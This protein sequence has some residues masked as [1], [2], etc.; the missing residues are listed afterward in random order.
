METVNDV[1]SIS[2]SLSYWEG[3]FQRSIVKRPADQYLPGFNLVNPFESLN[4][5]DE[6]LPNLKVMFERVSNKNPL[7]FDEWHYFRDREPSVEDISSKISSDFESSVTSFVLVAKSWGVEPVLMTQF[8]RFANDD[9]FVRSLY[10]R[11][12]QSLDFEKFVEQIDL[13]NQI[14][15]EVAAKYEVLLID[16]DRMVPKSSEFIYDSVH[17][18]TTGSEHVAEIISTKL[19]AAFPEQFVKGQA[20]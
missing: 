17:L 8:G 11:S 1:V 10:E 4:N 2:K 6:L 15:R 3:P 14:V 19:S 12:G 7:S 9:V 16:L 18:N 20:P 13:A 5:S